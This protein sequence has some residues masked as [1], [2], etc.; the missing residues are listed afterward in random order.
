MTPRSAPTIS[1][2]TVCGPRSWPPPPGRCRNL[3]FS[4][5]LGILCLGQAQTHAIQEFCALPDG[6]AKLAEHALKVAGD[7]IIALSRYEY[8]LMSR[9]GDRVEDNHVFARGQDV[10]SLRALWQTEVS[11]R[12]IP[13]PGMA[14]PEVSTIVEKRA[15]E[16]AA[17]VEE[18]MAY[19]LR[20]VRSDLIETL[21]QRFTEMI[22]TQSRTQAVSL[23]A[24][25]VRLQDQIS[26]LR[27]GAEATDARLAADMAL[28]ERTLAEATEKTR[29][30][31]GDAIDALLRNRS[32][33]IHAAIS[34]QL[35]Q[36]IKRKIRPA[37]KGFEKRVAQILA[38][39]LPRQ[40]AL[41]E[42]MIRRTIK[43]KNDA[44][45]DAIIGIGAKVD[46]HE[47]AIQSLSR[48]LGDLLRHPIFAP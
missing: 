23:E 2:F 36:D 43:L 38:E 12:D 42:P 40:E 18:N 35:Q 13:A 21:T 34:A 6:A 46:A 19:A 37:L 33:E 15:G 39:T 48:Y 27:E 16:L 5:G 28:L 7:G 45:D 4:N 11:L 30:A 24:R 29:S 26:A 1:A 25:S 20:R 8:G 41:V 10:E 22:E 44:Q 31:I 9:T 32:A 17:Q 47:E 3:P 14:A